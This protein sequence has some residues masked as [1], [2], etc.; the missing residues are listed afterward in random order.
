MK[1]AKSPIKPA[2]DSSL[3]QKAYEYF[4]EQ[5]LSGAL[6]PGSVISEHAIAEANGM[7]RTPVR[8]A[9]NAL[10]IEGFVERVPRYGTIVRAPDRE[11]IA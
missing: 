7:S 3:K 10:E 8:E 5:L 1:T 4:R 6:L 11:E 9:I 2:S